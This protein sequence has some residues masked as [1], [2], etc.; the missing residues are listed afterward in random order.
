MRQLIRSRPLPNLGT[1]TERQL[2][3]LV[4][5]VG[6]GVLLLTLGFVGFYLIDRSAPT[7][8]TLAERRIPQLEESI[9]KE[10]NSI[11]LRL[12]LAGAYGAAHRY[13][14]ALAQFDAILTA[15]PDQKTALVNRGDIR[16][17]GDDLD[18]AAADYRHLIAISKDGEFANVDVQLH[19]AYYGLGEIMLRQGKPAD[20][21]LNLKGAL[22]INRTDADTLNLLG[23]AYLRSGDAKAAIEPLRAAVQ[24][25]PVDWP[26]PYLTLAEAYGAL[27][28][29]DAAAWAGAMATFSSGDAQTARTTLLTLVAGP[30]AI[31]A[32]VGLGLVNE[33]AGDRAAALAAYQQALGRDPANYTALSGQMRLG[34]SPATSAPASASPTK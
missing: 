22:T 29:T 17:L 14:D 16:L 12:Q 21:I 23:L 8:V 18:G 4:A 7:E 3:R 25:V 9:R 6:V 2:N 30:A 5:I 24:F 11:D 26:Q 19:Q 28:Q 13:A 31:D 20:A 34:G 27:G 10:P 15:E 32:Y 33:G 1:L